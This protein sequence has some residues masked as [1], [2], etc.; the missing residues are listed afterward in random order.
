M[1]AE[2]G[3]RLRGKVHKAQALVVGEKSAVNIRI[4]SG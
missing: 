1:Q 4:I 2:R 3:A